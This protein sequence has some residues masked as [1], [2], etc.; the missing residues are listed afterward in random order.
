MRIVADDSWM[1][2]PVTDVAE[3]LSHDPV[4]PNVDQPYAGDSYA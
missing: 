4:T 3:D 2:D 1:L